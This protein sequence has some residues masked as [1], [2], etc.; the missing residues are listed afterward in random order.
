MQLDKEPLERLANLSSAQNVFYDECG[1]FTNDL[2]YHC[3]DCKQDDLDLDVCL[4]C[5]EVVGTRCWRPLQHR[6]ARTSI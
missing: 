1:H 6:M 2:Y 4:H 5:Y 3:Y